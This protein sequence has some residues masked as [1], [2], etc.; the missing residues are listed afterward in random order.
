MLSSGL[1]PRFPPDVRSYARKATPRRTWGPPCPGDC[2]DSAIFERDVPDHRT[3]SPRACCITRRRDPPPNSRNVVDV[4]V[5]SGRDH[6]SVRRS[7]LPPA[8]ACP[9]GQGSERS[10]S[11][12]AP[13]PRRWAGS[14]SA[15][16]RPLGS[17]EP[18]R[19]ARRLE[20]GGQEGGDLAPRAG[21]ARCGPKIDQ[22][23]PPDS[24]AEFQRCRAD[25]NGRS[26]AYPALWRSMLRS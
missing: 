5:A 25:S 8:V 2:V 19:L 17:S 14:T 4:S 26:K 20:L 23:P 18:P 9:S 21:D 16:A 10:M 6:I 13:P 24:S 3:T 7:E 11:S 12:N 15:R 1:R 22:K